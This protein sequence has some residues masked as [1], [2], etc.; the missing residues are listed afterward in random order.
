MDHYTVALFSFKK[1]KILIYWIEKF[2]GGNRYLNLLLKSSNR[3]GRWMV[4]GRD[5]Q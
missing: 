4:Q 1:D 2:G 5:R 3:E